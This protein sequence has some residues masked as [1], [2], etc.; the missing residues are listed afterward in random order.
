M[1]PTAATAAPMP[2]SRRAAH[3]PPDRDHAA[4]YKLVVLAPDAVDAVA[5]AGGLVVDA[6][7]AGWLVDFYL[8]TEAHAR[9]V[10]ILGATSQLMPSTFDAE[11]HRTDAVLFAASMYP[12]HREVRRFIADATRRHGA[13]VAAWGGTW[14]AAPA[15]SSDI[16]HRLSSAARAFKYYALKAAGTEV[17]ACTNEAFNGGFHRLT[18]VEPALPA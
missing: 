11:S 12:K 6:L 10:R 2:T 9:A 4:P 5:A 3:R 16:E 18:V 13:D 17:S 1:K 8:E 14:S 15:S 7:R